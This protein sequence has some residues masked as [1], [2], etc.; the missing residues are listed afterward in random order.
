MSK[1]DDY[2]SE[3]HRHDANLTSC[4]HGLP[5]ALLSAIRRPAAVV[6]QE[7]HQVVWVKWSTRK[8]QKILHFSAS[9]CP[10]NSVHWPEI[11]CGDLASARRKA[12]SPVGVV[13]AKVRRRSVRLPPSHATSAAF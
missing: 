7:V 5:A 4:L 9:P 8:G 6:T 11:S 10:G 12:W 3:T 13:D 2:P 1:L